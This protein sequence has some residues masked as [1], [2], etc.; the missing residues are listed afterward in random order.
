MCS[1]LVQP[2]SSSC[3]Q[4]VSSELLSLLLFKLFTVPV[5]TARLL[6]VHVRACVR[7]AVCLY[8]CVRVA[9]VHA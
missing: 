4:V 2:T 5:S 9:C 7:V 6:Y 1:S 3:V 8:V